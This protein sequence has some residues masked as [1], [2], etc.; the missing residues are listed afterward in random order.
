[1]TTQD[2][3]LIREAKRELLDDEGENRAVRGFLMLYGQPGVTAAQMKR[4]MERLGYPYAPDWVERSPGHLTKSGA[5]LWLRMLFDLELTQPAPPEQA[6]ARD[7][8]A[9]FDAW[10]DAGNLMKANPYNEGT[11]AFWAW[12]G[13]C[14]AIRK[15]PT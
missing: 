5:Q 9:A 13:W 6:D 10:W 11:P 12:E 4:H 8:S 2:A 3:D 7:T 14:A 1:M 15:E